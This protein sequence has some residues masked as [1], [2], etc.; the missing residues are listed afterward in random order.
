MILDK[1]QRKL[2]NRNKCYS[3][4]LVFDWNFSNAC[5]KK[6]RVPSVNKLKRKHHLVYCVTYRMEQSFLG[7]WISYRYTIC[8]KKKKPR[9][10]RSKYEGKFESLLRHFLKKIARLS[11]KESLHFDD[12]YYFVV[13]MNH[14]DLQ[15]DFF[16][17]IL[18]YLHLK[19]REHHHIKI[20]YL[21]RNRNCRFLDLVFA[22]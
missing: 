7:M 15:I 6:Y 18:S 13:K 12:S 21:N 22:E 1:I 3:F 16:F 5:L 20:V 10:L 4:P 11:K 9:L 17:N 2:Y 8:Q 14:F 19:L